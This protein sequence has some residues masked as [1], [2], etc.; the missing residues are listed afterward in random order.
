MK[1]YLPGILLSGTIA[2]V[3]YMVSLFLPKGILGGTLI[4]LILGMLLNPLL[5]RYKALETGI[6]WTSK[7]ILRT[8]IIL[9]GIALS[10]SQVFKAGKYAL[11]LMAF[12]LATAFTVGYLCKRVFKINWKV[13][14]LLSVSTAIC[15][16]T[17]VATLGPTIR[18]KNRDIAYAIS[19]T[20]LFDI[21]TVIAFPWIGRLLGLS[22]TGYGLWV[23]T[24]VN[25]TSS[26][27]AAGYAFSDA[28]GSLATIVKLTRTLFIVPVVLAFSWIYA[29]KEKPSQASEKINIYKIFPWF[30]LGFLT[31]VGIRTMDLIP[32]NMITKISFASKFFMSMAL[33]SIGLNTSLKEVKNVGLKPMIAGVVIDT[34]VVI[35]SLIA[36]SG[37]LRFV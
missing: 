37:I 20:F 4:A 3:S 25:D 27:V 2:A 10:F 11:I 8:G 7:I 23:G 33:A 26:V 13:A 21:I 1:K 35:V 18:A 14:S 16:G 28:A 17:A 24:A 22:D 31:V 15:G 32:A 36:Q 30:I 5:G 6:N 19:A 9:S 12:T 34:S 29:K